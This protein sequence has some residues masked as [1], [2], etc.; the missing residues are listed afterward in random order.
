MTDGKHLLIN[1]YAFSY[2]YSASFL[3]KNFDRVKQQGNFLGIVPGAFSTVTNVPV[4][5]NSIAAIRNSADFLAVPAYA[6]ESRRR[7]K[8]L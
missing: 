6:Q 2:V 3:F 7:G 1:D 5:K 4:L 8:I